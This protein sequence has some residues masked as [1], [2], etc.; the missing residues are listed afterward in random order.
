MNC[1]LCASPRMRSV[2][3][4]GVLPSSERFLCSDELDLPEIGYPLHLRLCEDCLLL[5]VPES[6]LHTVPAD[7]PPPVARSKR[8]PEARDFLDRAIGRLGLG[9]YSQIVQVSSHDGYLLR[10][11][12]EAGIPCLG[13]EASARAGTTARGLGV[14]TVTAFFDE[15]VA[16]DLYREYGPADLVVADHIFSQVQDIHSFVR[17]LRTL[18]ADHGTIS[19]EI[20]N[21][22]HLVRDK[23][24][25]SI[26]HGRLQYFTVLTA[27]RALAGGGLMVV[28]VEPVDTAGG[29]LRIW[30]RPE[31]TAP[32]QGPRVEDALA[33]ERNS[34]IHSAAG[35]SVLENHARAT[36]AAT[37]RL[38]LDYRDRDLSVIGYGAEGYSTVLNYCGIRPDLMRYTIDTDPLRQGTYTP[39]TRVPVRAPEQLHEDHPDVVMVLPWSHPP[40]PIEHLQYIDSW[41]GRLV[42][43]PP[44][45]PGA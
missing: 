35:Y 16:E 7:R 8:G 13:V 15:A 25:D 23:R 18:V 5:Q 28:D 14:P 42:F 39:G 38:L 21:A 43:P 30:A 12:V 17:G 2:L 11:A 44:T 32:A 20:H 22:L 9:S 41:G 3:D 4:L 37:L 40:D 1:R 34:G 10:H 26:D 27:M 45:A 6:A 31:E 24:F 36:R 33:E 19:L 29:T